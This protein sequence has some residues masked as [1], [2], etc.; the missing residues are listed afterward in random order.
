MSLKF[1]PAAWIFVAFELS[2]LATTHYVDLNS[3][4]PTAPYA[5]WSTAAMDIQSAIDSATDGDLILVTNGTYQ[6]GGRVANGLLTNRVVIN[7]AVTVQSANG[8]ASTVIRGQWVPGT[9]NG[10][11]AVR[12]AYLT[13][14]ASLTGFT[15]TSGAT[16]TNGQ[17]LDLSGG[18]VYCESTNSCNLSECIIT[19]NAAAV[20]GGGI[21]RG[22]LSNCTISGNVL[23]QSSPIFP[24]AGAGA[25]GAVLEG[26]SV[27]SNTIP[28]LA[29][30]DVGSGAGASAS[31]LR[32]CSIVANQ[33]FV[34]FSTGFGGGVSSCT[35]SNCYLAL[36]YAAGIGGGMY[37]SFAVNCFI[38]SNTASASGA[39]GG[40]GAGASSTNFILENCILFRNLAAR[41]GG[42][43]AYLVTLKNCT[44]VENQVTNTPIS[45]GAGCANATC[46]NSIIYFNTALSTN[47]NL[48]SLSGSSFYC[49]TDPTF[50]GR[51]NFAAAP[52]FVDQANGNLR[53]QS[54]S[55][56]INSGANTYSTV[57]VDYDGNSRIVGGTVDVG[58][59]EF[60]TP[61]SV[62][63]YS[64]AA[65]Y[66][67]ATDGSAD[68]VDTDGDGQNNWQEWQADMDPTNALSVFK[69]TSI[70]TNNPIKITWNTPVP[71]TRSYFVERATKLNPVS[72][73]K[74]VTNLLQ[75]QF[76]DTSATNA[77]PY[78]YR[79]GVQ[80]FN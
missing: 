27:S 9:T 22:N 71:L 66:G 67:L 52:L 50:A 12:C 28:I 46:I 1:A 53:L 26:C 43:G 76:F 25:Y 23:I 65:K 11:S 78:F 3:A 77:G 37:N 59:F 20:S 36:N 68:F 60:Q 41:Y 75:Q 16:G 39:P 2:A 32:N 70:S 80:G 49:C 42:G 73:Q 47:S 6:T 44:V 55:P 56:C 40:G 29:G 38:T 31:T 51:G 13:N 63:S 7:K 5:N 24:L 79:V 72:F 8:T 18:G 57:P 30:G 61:A 62:L 34:P 4:A 48:F 58:A 74:L 14:G 10:P 21:Y 15:L 33:N 69:I 35:L 54:N 19:A 17:A 64:W 45:G